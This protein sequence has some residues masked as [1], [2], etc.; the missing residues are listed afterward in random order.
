[1]WI[2]TGFDYLYYLNNRI[3]YATSIDS[4]CRRTRGKDN[5]GGD[6]MLY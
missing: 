4:F 6:G 3:C 1:M 5:A 2:W